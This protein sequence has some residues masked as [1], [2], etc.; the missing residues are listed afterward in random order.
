MTKP[1]SRSFARSVGEVT[2]D[3]ASQSAPDTS[4]SCKVTAGGSS[5][6]R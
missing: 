5:S 4:S 2:S 6:A 1:A 3:M